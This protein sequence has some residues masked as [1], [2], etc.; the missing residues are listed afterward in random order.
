VSTWWQ[1]DPVH[2]GWHS[3]TAGGNNS[4]RGVWEKGASVGMVTGVRCGSGSGAGIWIWTW[5]GKC[6]VTCL[7]TYSCVQCSTCQRRSSAL[8][9]HTLS[10]GRT[11]DVSIR[12]ALVTPCRVK[13]RALAIPDR[14]KRTFARVSHW[15]VNAGGEHCALV[16]VNHTLVIVLKDLRHTW[17]QFVQVDFTS[18]AHESWILQ[19]AVN[20]MPIG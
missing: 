5:A 14:T 20:G 15:R 17:G 18:C 19:G 8:I 2:P 16:G 10:M 3:H 1:S 12:R 7:F 4:G 9:Q 11:G 13:G 6:A